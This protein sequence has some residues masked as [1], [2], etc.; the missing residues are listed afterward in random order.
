MSEEIK[1]WEL[2]V[3]KSADDAVNR[4][5]AAVLDLAARMQKL[6][7]V[8]ERQARRIDEL[9][10][11]TGVHDPRFFDIARELNKDDDQSSH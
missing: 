7:R 9:E 4:L 5:R 10:D 3:G 8:I 11:R 1:P 6:E 2:G